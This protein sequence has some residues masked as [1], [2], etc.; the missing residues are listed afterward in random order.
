MEKLQEHNKRHIVCGAPFGRP[1]WTEI[2]MKGKQLGRVWIYPSSSQLFTFRFLSF[3]SC[4]KLT[5][6]CQCECCFGRFLAKVRVWQA[7]RTHMTGF[8]LVFISIPIVHWIRNK[9]FP[10]YSGAH[11]VLLNNNCDGS[12]T[13]P[14][15]QYQKDASAHSFGA[16]SGHIRLNIRRIVNDES[17]VW[18]VSSVT[19]FYVALSRSRQ[20]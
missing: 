14:R 2:A 17:N 18:H 6:I 9:A 3:F 5:F 20:T 1:E 7:T 4:T 15:N 13:R 19:K 12:E 16:H 8:W 10:C 11:G